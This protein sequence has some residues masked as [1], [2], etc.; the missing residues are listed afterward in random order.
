[1]GREKDRIYEKIKADGSRCAAR[2]LARSIFCYF[3]NPAKAHERQEAQRAGGIER[4]RR[5][6]V[7]P[8]ETPDWPVRNSSDVAQLLVE[9]LS[10]VRRGQLDTKVATYVDSLSGILLKALAMGPLEERLAALETLLKH[11]PSQVVTYVGPGT[12]ERTFS[13]QARIREDNDDDKS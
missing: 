3:H 2:P 12:E 6:A 10:Q 11:Q 8:L 4:S 5:A 7:L 9:T 1:M 13:S